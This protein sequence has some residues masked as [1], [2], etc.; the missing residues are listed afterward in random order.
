MVRLQ[1]IAIEDVNRRISM[2]LKLMTKS[3]TRLVYCLMLMSFAAVL[4][5]CS[6][7]ITPK[8]NYANIA[9]ESFLLYK[10]GEKAYK[11]GNYEDA[12]ALLT[13]FVNKYPDDILHKIG[14]YYLGR[15]FEA[16]GETDKAREYYVQIIEQYSADFWAESAQRRLKLL[17]A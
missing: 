12:I 5:G 17:D 7:S 11:S 16:T 3:K 10:E 9:D 1:V 4:T 6:S 13:Q 14:L 8:T 15:S 2:L